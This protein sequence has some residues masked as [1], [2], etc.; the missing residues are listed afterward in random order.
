M[1]VPVWEALNQLFCPIAR[2]NLPIQSVSTIPSRRKL[3]EVR[4]DVQAVGGS[5]N[6]KED[7][8]EPV[9]VAVRGG[10]VCCHVDCG[11]GVGEGNACEVPV[12][13]EPAELEK[14]GERLERK[15]E[16][17]KGGERGTHFFVVDIFWG[18]GRER[19]RG[20]GNG[21][22]GSEGGKQEKE[23]W[24]LT[25]S[26]RN[27]FLSLRNQRKP[28]VSPTILITA[29]PRI[30]SKQLTLAQAFKYNPVP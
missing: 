27:E 21:Q 10:I 1:Y 7:A 11:V 16:G 9:G 8:D 30:I 20:G 24:K 12:G 19:W 6:D 2:S 4:R 26:L 29:T 25:P 23:R 18:G 17:E 15:V 22:K 28:L 13:E 14:K 5:E 3:K